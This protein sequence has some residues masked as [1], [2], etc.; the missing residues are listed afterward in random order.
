MEYLAK[1]QELRTVT[2]K[3]A[4]TSLLDDAER[5]GKGQPDDVWA[6]WEG[7]YGCVYHCFLKRAKEGT[8]FMSMDAQTE[9]LREEIVNKFP[10]DKLIMGK[11]IPVLKVEEDPLR[12]VRIDK[13]E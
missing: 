11:R 4:N 1:L 2:V 5:L 9:N 10:L 7:S 12:W 13:F 8:A 6:Q 3:F